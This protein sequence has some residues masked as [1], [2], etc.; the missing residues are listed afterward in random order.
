[1]KKIAVV[2]ILFL[3]I[4]SVAHAGQIAQQKLVKG[5][6]VS[7]ETEYEV[8]D[9]AISN[10]QIC[11][12]MVTESRREIYLNPR[13]EGV[14]SLTI[15]DK[16]GRK[17]EIVP[18]EVYKSDLEELANQARALFKDTN[19]AVEVTAREVILSGE[20]T[21]KAVLE[22]AA[23]F[24]MRHPEALNRV[25][26]SGE[27]MQTVAASAQAAIKMPGIKVRNVRGTLLL[28]GVAYSSS[29]AK[30][31]VEIAKLYESNIINLLEIKETGRRPG[32][33]KLVKL[34]VYFM[35]V[36]TEALRSFGINWAPGSFPKGDGSGE[37]SGGIAGLGTSLI[38]FIFN[39]VPKIKFLRERGQAKVLDNATIIVKSGEVAD[40]FN[41]TQVPYYSGDNVTFK[42]V[43]IKVHVE[44]IATKGAVDIVINAE[45]SS[46][47]ANIDAGID[48]RKISTNAYVNAGRSV[49]LA[50]MVSNREVKTYNKKPTGIDTSS[51][52]FSLALSKDFQSG[53][54]KFVIFIKPTI[55]EDILPAE[56]KL[57][58]FFQMEE[59]MVRDRSK[60][61]YEEF[62]KEKG[63][64]PKAKKAPR[65]K[66]W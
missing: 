62:M 51:A 39:L 35:E 1:M 58:E 64:T 48:T 60:K 45:I 29:A 52:L 42:D 32:Q 23:S 8:G 54:S 14:T 15:W 16:E 30:R 2:F 4:S 5:K 26:M 22:Q 18:I 20:A 13:N 21:S 10:D 9:V 36:K 65:R 3:G 59:E 37:S 41:G 44:P 25:T 28:E 66:Q 61:E 6:A 19:V 33:D 12:F 40:F 17:R 38:G 53:R 56:E 7:L 27:V 34:D 46:P 50:N 49:V 63:V 47:A 11:D 31:A 43:G 55:L 24:G 57:R